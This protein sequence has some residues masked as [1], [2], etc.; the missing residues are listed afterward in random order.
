MDAVQAADVAQANAESAQ[1]RIANDAIADVDVNSCLARF[2]AQTATTTSAEF[3][4]AS[5]RRQ[6]FADKDLQKANT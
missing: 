1:Q 6:L 3:S 5:S 4:A 2:A